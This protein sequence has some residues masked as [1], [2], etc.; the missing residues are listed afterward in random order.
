MT[1]V[2][3]RHGT[4]SL[5]EASRPVSNKLGYSG[6]WAR[7]AKWS[8]YF[9]LI[10]TY[11]PLLWLALMSVSEKPLSGLPFPLSFEHYR[12]LAAEPRWIEP[13]VSSILIGL[14]VSIVC[15]IVATAVGRAIP[16]SRRP[17][18]LVLFAILPLFVPGMS[19]GAALF[20]FFRS[21]LDLKLGYWAVFLGHVVW[22]MPFSLLMVLVIAVR[23]D[24]RLLEA[25]ED[26]GANAWRRFVDIEY[27]ILRPGIVGAGLFGFLLS[28]NEILRS[29]FL[30]GIETTMPVW[31]WTMAA[32][33]QSQVPVIFSLSTIVLIITLPML[34]GF[35]WILFVKLDHG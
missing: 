1:A 21:F 4:S 19:M 16:N 13:F 12:S 34:G 5:P 26:L 31:N 17:G 29:I 32:S 9:A 6:G 20:I 11:F 28:F 7:L 10:L 30:R 22:A 24:Y 14:A 8:G 27:P 3:F 25:A 2:D 18:T 35:F 23:F 15:M 33:Q